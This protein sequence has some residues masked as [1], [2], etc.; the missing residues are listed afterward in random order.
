MD[1]A[2]GKTGFEAGSQEQVAHACQHLRYRAQTF[3]DVADTILRVVDAIERDFEPD[4]YDVDF[5][6]HN[7]LCVLEQMAWMEADLAEFRKAIDAQR[8]KGRER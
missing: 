5:L 6:H 1:Y 4:D 7:W 2:Y 8:A 3:A